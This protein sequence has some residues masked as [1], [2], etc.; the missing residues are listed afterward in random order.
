MLPA[1]LCSGTS[2]GA[3][4][5][6]LAAVHFHG[7]R[8]YPYLAP[9][10]SLEECQVAASIIGIDDTVATAR[11]TLYK[12]FGCYTL[13]NGNLEFNSKVETYVSSFASE[14]K[15]ENTESCRTNQ[16]VFVMAC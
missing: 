15:E 8:D 9:I 3:C 4:C 16:S 14:A 2:D 6:L 1:H 5:L 10:Q 11:S 12:V 13:A 7:V